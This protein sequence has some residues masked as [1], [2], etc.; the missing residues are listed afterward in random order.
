MQHYADWPDQPLPALG[1]RTPR[2]VVR[3]AKGR[4]E[5][6]LLIKTMENFEHRG[7]GSGECFDFSGIRRELGLV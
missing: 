7:G 1:G 3:T 6:D 2:E 5:V 4:V